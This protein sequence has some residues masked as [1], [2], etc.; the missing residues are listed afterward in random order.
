[1]FVSNPDRVLCIRLKSDKEKAIRLDMLLNRVPFT[2]QRLPDDRRPGK[3][4]SAGVWPV[5]RC[6]RIYTE[7]GHTLMMEGDENGTRFACGLTVVT[8]GRIEDC[9]A[10]LVAHEAGEVVIYLAASTD[11]REEDF[12]GNVKS[13]L[14]AARAK[15]HADI[16]ACLLYTSR[17]V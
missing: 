3:F 9:Y 1:M 7:N 13:S 4:V 8:D 14:A 6:E 17:C 15:G 10:K 16:R 12:V 2:D 11:N 5:T